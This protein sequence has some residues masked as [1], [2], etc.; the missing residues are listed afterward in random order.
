MPA[1]PADEVLA[2]GL[3]FGRR[4]PTALLG[5]VVTRLRLHWLDGLPELQTR[6]VAALPLVFGAGERP[7][8]RLAAR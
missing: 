1:W 8:R 2:S 4:A 3:S 5:W 6:L 7:A